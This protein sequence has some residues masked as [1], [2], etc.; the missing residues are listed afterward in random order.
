VDGVKLTGGH[1]VATAQTAKAACRLASTAR[2]HGCTGTQT[3]VLC[4]LRTQGTRT[5]TTYYG[6]HRFSVGN[7]HTQQVGNLAHHFLSTNGAHQ[8]LNA[9]GI[10]T[11][12]ECVGKTTASSKSATTAVGT[13]Q[14]F[15]HLTDTRVFIDSEFLGAYIEHQCGNQ[16]DSAQHCYCNQN[17]IHKVNY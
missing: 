15:R 8:S 7:G 17:E 12:D 6:N 16:S 10:G 11:L 4:N 1:T 2:V 5:V 13:R 14:L 9:S 3:T